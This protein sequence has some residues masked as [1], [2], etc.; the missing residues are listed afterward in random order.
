[1]NGDGSAKDTWHFE[2]SLEGSGLTYEDGDALGVRPTKCAELAEEILRVPGRHVTI[3]AMTDSVSL[4]FGLL[5]GGLSSR[6]GTDKASLDWRGQPLWQHQLRLAAEI[7]ANEILI[8]GKP[9][10]PYR[11]AAKTVA[12]E[13]PG[14]GPLAGLAALLAAMKSDWLVAVAVDM[15]FLDRTTLGLL[16]DARGDGRGVV[17]T[18]AGRAE[19]L[20]AIYPRALAKLARVKAGSSDRSLQAFVC[21]AEAAGLVRL[22]PWNAERAGCFRSVNTRADWA[23]AHGRKS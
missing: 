7:G 23:A 20:A 14:R 3:G 17:P 22:L 11:D 8:S 1:M 21:D 2:F 10:G 4:C 19:P 12:D 15:P 16:L 9:D 6:M 13:F 18:I 5:A